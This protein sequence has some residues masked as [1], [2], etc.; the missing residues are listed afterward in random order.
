MVQSSL[1]SRPGL[2]YSSKRKFEVSYMANDKVQTYE[3]LPPI[4]GQTFAGRFFGSK[5]FLGLLLRTALP[6]AVQNLITSTVN[7]IDTVMITPLGADSIAAVGQVNM[8]FFFY[9]VFLFGINNGGSIFYAQY[10]GRGD[11]HGIRSILAI[12][13]RLS[14]VV[15]LMFTVASL[16]FRVPL[17][18]LLA[19]EPELVRIGS[20]YLFILAWSFPAFALTQLFSIAL[21]SIG[22]PKISMHAS[23][24]A[25][26]INVVLNYILIYGKLGFPALGVRGA[27]IATIIARFAEMLWVLFFALKKD[28]PVRVP[29]RFLAKFDALMTRQYFRFATP[30]IIT[31]SLWSFSQLLFTMAYVRISTEAAAG[32]QL[33]GTIQNFFYILAMSLAAASAVVVGNALGAN[34]DADR[35]LRPLAARIVRLTV[36][37]GLVCALAAILVPD[38]FLLV[39]QNLTPA[40]HEITANLLRIRGLFLIIRFL[41]SVMILG[42]YRAG[43]DVKIPMLVE[44]ATIY[45]FAVPAVFIVGLVLQWGIYWALIIV[46]L[47]EL[48]KLVI[49]YPRYVKGKWLNYV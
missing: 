29:W 3:K 34:E 12:C 1:A 2:V 36:T 18:R 16:V 45:L 46:S 7:M 38:V 24:L 43:G 44:L 13:L 5:S 25:F 35:V 27:A 42:I 37:I 14:L 17:M 30:V 33:S 23:I 31:E 4:V 41:N 6:V 11:Q 10:H 39:F 32:I 26:A 21:R 48:L 49:L 9:A 19:P 20:D 28:S 8:F 15:S 40:L 22:R 47:E